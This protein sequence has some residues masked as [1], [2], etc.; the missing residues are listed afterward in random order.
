MSTAGCMANNVTL[1][2]DLFP[3]HLP[4]YS[5]LFAQAWLS[6]TKGY[7]SNIS[8]LVSILKRLIKLMLIC[9]MLS[10]FIADNILKLIF[11]FFFFFEKINPCPTE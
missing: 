11:F 8:V 9:K 6:H 7:N 1:I 10:K 2:R 4:Y 3:E 5:I